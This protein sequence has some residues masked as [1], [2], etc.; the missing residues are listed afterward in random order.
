[1]SAIIKSSRQ[2]KYARVTKKKFTRKKINTQY[3]VLVAYIFKLMLALEG[4]LINL[5]PNMTGSPMTFVY[6]HQETEITVLSVGQFENSPNTLE[7]IYT[8]FQNLK[9]FILHMT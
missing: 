6:F 9:K 5:Y 7:N 4:P 2:R 8:T 3:L 1:M